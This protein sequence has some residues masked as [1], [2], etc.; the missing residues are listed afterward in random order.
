MA[1]AVEESTAIIASSAGNSFSIFAEI[2]SEELH[3]FGECEL[4]RILPF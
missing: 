1:E 2:R 4:D 3:N